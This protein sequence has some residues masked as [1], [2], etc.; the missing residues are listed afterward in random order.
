LIIDT[1]PV[2]AVTDAAILASSASGTILVIEQGRTTFPALGRAKK[3]LDRVGAHTIGAVMNKVRASSGSYSYDYGYYAAA[4]DVSAK[5]SLRHQGNGLLRTALGILQEVGKSQS[6]AARLQITILTTV[7]I[8]IATL[9]SGVILARA[10]GP[11]G[12]GVLTAAMLYGPLLVSVGSLGIAEALVYRSSR[13][14]TARSP[15]LVTA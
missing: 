2:N 11:A 13:E 8:L 6:T 15:A 7:V 9:G 3:M 12:R 1:P 5:S 10:L 4:S 14:D